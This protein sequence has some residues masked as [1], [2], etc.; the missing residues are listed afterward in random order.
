[1]ATLDM[2]M[3]DDKLLGYW[4]KMN[5]SHLDDEIIMIDNFG[6][7]VSKIPD[8]R[9]LNII[10]S[11]HRFWLRMI[12]ESTG[13]YLA[14]M[15]PNFHNPWELV[16]TVLDNQMEIARDSGLK[17]FYHR[18]DSISLPKAYVSLEKII[19]K[20]MVLLENRQDLK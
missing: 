9:E 7:F 14:S 15:R 17:I 2:T 18:M 19:L 8:D 6:R 12:D 4:F 3:I 13:R 16:I 5:E 20:K 10:G 11:W 1:M